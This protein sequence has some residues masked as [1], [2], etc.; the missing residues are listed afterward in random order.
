MSM[1]TRKILTMAALLTLAVGLFSCKDEPKK[2]AENTTQQEGITFRFTVPGGDAHVVDT[3]AVHD[4]PEW[5]IDHLWMYVFDES[6]ETLS[7]D[8]IDISETPEFKFSGTDAKYTYKPKWE[9]KNEQRQFFFVANMKVDLKKDATKAQLLAKVHEKA[10]ETASTD[11]LYPAKSVNEKRIPMTAYATQGSSRVIALTGN[12]TVDVK[13]KRTVARIDIVNRIPGFTITKLELFNAFKK[14]NVVEESTNVI[15]DNRLATSVAPFATLDANNTI[16]QRQGTEIKKAFYLYEGKNVGVPDNEIT[17]IKITADYG[18]LKGRI[19]KIPFKA[20]DPASGLFTAVKDVQRN[21]LYKI[22]LGD[23]IN[24][25]K[26]LVDF[27][28][29]EEDWTAV[30]FEET[31]ALIYVT[32]QPLTDR[33]DMGA[34][35]NVADNAAHSYTLQL[36]NDFAT[37]TAYDKPE[38]LSGKDWITD[39]AIAPGTGSKATL[40]FNVTANASGA[41]RTGSIKLKSTANAAFFTLTVKQPK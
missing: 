31:L 15:T 19:F 2:A 30:D 36:D 40:T 20:K 4:N 22:T 17:Y 6:G 7:Q 41:P 24:P 14:A 21:H 12:A 38:V 5:A 9:G 37:H 32:G 23:L 8:P 28:I 1:K 27:K 25:T 39:V 29:E 18:T 35:L 10:M 33:S 26:G 34:T 16:G 13:L 11:I 3:R